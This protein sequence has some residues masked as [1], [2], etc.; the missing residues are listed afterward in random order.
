MSRRRPKLNRLEE[1]LKHLELVD[2]NL[3]NASNLLDGA[4]RDANTI[5]DK[6]LIRQLKSL[7]FHITQLHPCDVA[8]M[9]L[10]E[11]ITQYGELMDT[12]ERRRYDIVR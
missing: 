11:L 7:R 2:L 6:I 1:A 4:L 5:G 10:N 3:H 9:M 12:H 8:T